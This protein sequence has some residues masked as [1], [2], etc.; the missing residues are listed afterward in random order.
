MDV[1]KTVRG[2]GVLETVCNLTDVLYSEDVK[3]KVGEVM[4]LPGENIKDMLPK[5]AEWLKGFKKEN[6]MF[7][8]PEIA[9]EDYCYESCK[10]AVFMI[11]CGISD[12]IKESIQGN[13]PKKMKVNVLEE[14]YFPENFYPSNG[15][16]VVVG[17]SAAGHKMVLPETYRLIEKY[18]SFWGKKVFVPYVELED[19]VRYEGWMEISSDMFNETW[20]EK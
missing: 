17:Y 6:Y 2:I 3:S 5:I 19:A 12:E 18:S 14:P 11:P 4:P 8:T 1:L 16:I 13:L 20:R 10:E 7:F 15:I 9:L